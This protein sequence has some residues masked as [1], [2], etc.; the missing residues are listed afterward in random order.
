MSFKDMAQ[1]LRIVLNFLKLNIKMNQ[2]TKLSF[3][4][5]IPFLGTIDSLRLYNLEN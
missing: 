2:I 5:T 1:E 3:L 4:G